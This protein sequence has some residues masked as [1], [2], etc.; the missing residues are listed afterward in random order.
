MTPL[1]DSIIDQLPPPFVLHNF[2][3]SPPPIS[4][5]S[6]LYP[7]LPPSIDHPPPHHL[8]LNQSCCSSLPPSLSPAFPPSNT[9]FLPTYLPINQSPSSPPSI[10][11]LLP[12]V[13]FLL[14]HPTTHPP[15]PSSKLYM[16]SWCKCKSEIRLLFISTS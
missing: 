7:Y 10:N 13:T 9:P 11:H 12:P 14:S 16:C 4:I 2:H 6:P 3:Q 15:L 5:N 8:L 1:P